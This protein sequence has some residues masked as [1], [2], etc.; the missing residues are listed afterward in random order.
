MIKQVGMSVNNINSITVNISTN[1]TT[2]YTL[3]ILAKVPP[4][5]PLLLHSMKELLIRFGLQI[6]KLLYAIAGQNP[7]SMLMGPLVGVHI[8]RCMPSPVRIP[9]VC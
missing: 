4:A 5:N 2:I 7:F 1:L 8:D 6:S 3:N 9:L